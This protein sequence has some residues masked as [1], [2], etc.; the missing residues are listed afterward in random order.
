MLC[1]FSDIIGALL[2]AC[3]PVARTGWFKSIAPHPELRQGALDP[4]GLIADLSAAFP[5]ARLLESGV[6]YLIDDQL[7]LHRDLA[8]PD[9]VWLPVRGRRKEIIDVVGDS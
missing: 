1:K 7:H 4:I 3:R 6:A 8:T 2:K 5:Q 9:R